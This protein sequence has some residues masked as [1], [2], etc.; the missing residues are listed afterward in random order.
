[1]LLDDTRGTLA[2]AV[3]RIVDKDKTIFVLLHMF[4]ILSQIIDLAYLYSCRI[5]MYL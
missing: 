4:V 5:Y 2:G 1:M 3:A